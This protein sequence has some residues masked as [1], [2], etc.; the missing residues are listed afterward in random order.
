MLTPFIDKPFIF[1]HPQVWK[2]HG[3]LFIT[4]MFIK[5]IWFRAQNEV[6]SYY[7]KTNNTFHIVDLPI[8]SL[9]N[10]AQGNDVAHE[11]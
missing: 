2:N 9:K 7:Y 10:Y 11:S 3:N 1:F 8:L 5:G 6:F 4:Y